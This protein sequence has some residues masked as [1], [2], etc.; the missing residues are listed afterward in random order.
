MPTVDSGGVP[1]FYEVVGNGRP[2]VLVHGFTQSFDTCWRHTGR[3]DELVRA[4]R[5]VIG[6]DC[7]GHGRSGKPYDSSAYDA[8]QVPN[9]V[10]TVM[11]AL[12]LQRADLVG[13][14]M[15]GWIALNLLARFPERFARVAAGGSGPRP[16]RQA[17]IMIHALEVDD[18][19]TISD[20]AARGF[21]SFVDSSEA[22]DRKAL[23]ALQRANRAAADPALLAQVRVPTLLFVGAED[24]TLETVRQAEKHRIDP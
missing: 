6:L 22:N 23:A 7:R 24:P 10:L 3:V 19:A 21:R 1:I 15:G 2:L 4:G 5:K 11:D 14:S 13:Y 12:D 16:F 20:P 17:E 9:D 18:P 8:N